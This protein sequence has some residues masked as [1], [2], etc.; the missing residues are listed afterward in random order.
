MNSNNRII[1]IITIIARIFSFFIPYV[2]KLKIK[3][4]GKSKGKNNQ[5]FQNIFC[6]SPLC[7]HFLALFGQTQQNNSI[8]TL[9]WRSHTSHSLSSL[10]LPLLLSL[11]PF[12]FPFLCPF[13]FLFSPLAQWPWKWQ[14]RV[15]MVSEGILY[16]LSLSPLIKPWSCHGVEPFSPPMSQVSFWGCTYLRKRVPTQIGAVLVFFRLS[17]QRGEREREANIITKQNHACVTQYTP[18]FMTV[19]LH[20][21][22][23]CN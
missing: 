13:F 18:A 20:G 12:S 16:L 6:S 5:L 22:Y 10:I 1:I 21:H 4:T 8:K 23:L 17:T 7:F 3:K 15:A 2:N 11:A 9:P 14:S 19:N